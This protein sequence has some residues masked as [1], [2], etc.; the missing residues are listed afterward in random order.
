MPAKAVFVDRDDTLIEDPGFLT[1]PADVR[2]LPGVDL[3]LR[4]LVQ[5][6]YKIVV[7]TNQ[8]AVARGLLTE[9]RLQ[10]IHL[11]LRRQLEARKLHLDGIYFC[12]FHPDGTVAEYAKESEL[13]KPSPGMLLQAAQDLEIDLE[14]S[15]MVGD[16]A[17]DVIAGRRAGCKTVR[18][19]G[20]FR[21]SDQGQ[22]ESEDEEEARADFT[23][24]N[25]VDAARVILRADAGVAVDT[26]TIDMAGTYAA[27]RK[28]HQQESPQRPSRR[29][30]D[31]YEYPSPSQPSGDMD[32]S[33][34]LRRMLQEL[35][36][37]SHRMQEDRFT[38]SKMVAGVFQILA[39]LGL[40][41]TFW[42]MWK[43][44]PQIELAKVW[45]LITVVLQIMALSFFV[46]HRQR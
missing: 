42:S 19:R 44:S 45:G 13:R 38:V 33:E 20:R 3:A 27:L 12:P 26:D 31:D 5:S 14:A 22:D 32:D 29:P 4:S 16:R 46:M 37:L 39:M 24:R 30:E 9:E 10:E 18:I 6:D 2:L 17:R 23:V 7:V 40:W 36:R 41:M 28:Q 35:M 11:E 25:F 43:S 21:P 15:W 1:D 34:V 8:S